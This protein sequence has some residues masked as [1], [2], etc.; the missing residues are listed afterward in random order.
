MLSGSYKTVQP[1]SKFGS[2]MGG[3]QSLQKVISMF[4]RIY[5]EVTS[6]ISAGHSFSDKGSALKTGW[7]RQQHH[8]T[9]ACQN[10]PHIRQS[11]VATTQK[12]W[13]VTKQQKIVRDLNLSLCYF[14]QE[15]RLK[16]ITLCVQMMWLILDT[17]LFDLGK[18]IGGRGEEIILSSVSSGKISW[19]TSHLKIALQFLSSENCWSSVLTTT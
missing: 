8:W 1:R 19:C 13:G 2:Q 12:M 16:F 18:W 4:Y 5:Q 14:C 10:A 7:E 3:S 15:M 6:L 11:E 9:I 17:V